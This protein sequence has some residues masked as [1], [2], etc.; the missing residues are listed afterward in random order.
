MLFRNTF[1]RLILDGVLSAVTQRRS[2]VVTL[3][4]LN[5]A[6]AQHLGSGSRE[7]Q[8]INQSIRLWTRIFY[9]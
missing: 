3:R 4:A 8:E 7:F 6:L 9:R 2:A 5:V 1:E